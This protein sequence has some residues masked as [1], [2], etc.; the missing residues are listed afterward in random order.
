[1]SLWDTPAAYLVRCLDDG[2]TS[3]AGI[4]LQ[5]YF[6]WERVSH[7]LCSNNYLAKA[8]AQYVLESGN[9]HHDS[10]HPDPELPPTFTDEQVM[11]FTHSPDGLPTV[12]VV[13]S[14]DRIAPGG[15]IAVYLHDNQ[16]IYEPRLGA[17]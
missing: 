5:N 13:A 2:D 11:E 9:V 14:D 6:S 12:L 3:Q 10:L 1:M 16:L 4:A 17:L 8:T 7:V 15:I